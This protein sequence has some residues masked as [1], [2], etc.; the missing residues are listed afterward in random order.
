MFCPSNETLQSITEKT[1][2]LA[3]KCT[4][5]IRNNSNNSS[6]NSDGSS[7]TGGGGA[8][9]AA[10]QAATTGGHQPV[11]AVDPQRTCKD[12]TA[13]GK[14]EGRPVGLGGGGTLRCFCPCKGTISKLM[15]RKYAA[16]K[17][18]QGQSQRTTKWYVKVIQ[19]A[20]CWRGQCGKYFIACRERERDGGVDK[21]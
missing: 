12:G 8:A 16:S 4:Q 11:P 19:M 9:G 6:N 14:D 2:L 10:A 1:K 21:A 18:Q 17:E 7:P 15:G 3:H 5:Q 13:G 20:S